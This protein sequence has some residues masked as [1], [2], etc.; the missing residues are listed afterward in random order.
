MSPCIGLWWCWLF[1][2]PG[3]PGSWEAA[4]WDVVF[5]LLFAEPL[6]SLVPR[7]HS[8][9]IFLSSQVFQG[10]GQEPP[11]I[12]MLLEVLL[13]PLL[14]C[15]TQYHPSHPHSS[16][17]V[18]RMRMTGSHRWGQLSTSVNPRTLELSTFK[19][20]QPLAV[21]PGGWALAR[22]GDPVISI[23]RRAGTTGLPVLRL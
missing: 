9:V 16:L 14:V 19:R 1:C 18:R 12:L 15:R 6:C 2:L 4:V 22:Q 10:K 21:P 8:L 11:A 23:W 5:P 7:C 20:Y 3:S 17:W 13:V